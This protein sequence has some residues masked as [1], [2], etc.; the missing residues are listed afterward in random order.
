MV[1]G[2]VNT[3]G[4][5]T[6]MF[7]ST[8]GEGDCCAVTGAPAVKDVMTH[9]PVTASTL[10][11]KLIISAHPHWKSSGEHYQ[12]ASQSSTDIDR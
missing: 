4:M 2:P 8:A 6:T 1:P 9:T 3:P 5:R 10:L 11:I 12:F 7:L